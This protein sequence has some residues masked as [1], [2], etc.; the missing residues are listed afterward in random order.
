M[1]YASLLSTK[2]IWKRKQKKRDNN[3]QEYK[4]QMENKEID[5]KTRVW[6]PGS[7]VNR[8]KQT[9]EE[10]VKYKKSGDEKS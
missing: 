8:K 10:K 2:H 6:W 1:T 5:K 4:E 7:V 9:K 3:L